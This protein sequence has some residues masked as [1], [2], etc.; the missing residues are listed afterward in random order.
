MLSAVGIRLARKIGL[1]RDGSSLGLSP[2]ESEL[3]RRLWYQLARVDSQISRALGLN[4]SLDLSCGDVKKP[5][6]VPDEDLFP[7]M[8]EDPPEHDGITSV[9]FLL[10]GYELTHTMNSISRLIR[11][12]QHTVDKDRLATICIDMAEIIADAE[13]VLETR[14]LRYCDPTNG[15]HTL[16][17]VFYRAGMCD[18]R[19]SAYMP[20]HT[21]QRAGSEKNIVL[22][23]S[24]QLL[25]YLAMLNGRRDGLRKFHWI[26]GSTQSWKALLSALIEAR[27]SS[28][29]SE[30]ETV[31][32]EMEE[33]YAQWPAM[34]M[35]F[36]GS[37]S[38][39]VVKWTLELWEHYLKLVKAESSPI[40]DVPGFIT[41]LYRTSIGGGQC[42]TSNG[43]NSEV[44]VP[45]K[46]SLHV[47]AEQIDFASFDTSEFPSLL[48]FENDPS[49]WMQWEQ[50]FGSTR[51]FN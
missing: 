30:I 41:A 24:L 50:I 39:A 33:L 38:T 5:R 17:S 23:N 27:R 46:P 14:Y 44:E 43:L 40:P 22:T 42:E 51:G 11:E 37:V 47:D 45:A 18:M 12:A 7:E 1:H 13:E 2:F 20:K 36:K 32:D 26:Q 10:F 8:I 48:S 3:R 49:E 15:Y 16:L 25:R 34:F 4:P 6:N 21:P 28:S 9:S 35:Q 29:T 31:W 19:L